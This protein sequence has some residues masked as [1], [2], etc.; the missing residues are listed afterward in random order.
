MGYSG[1]TK[2]HLLVLVVQRHLD[3][4]IY[5]GE[6]AKGRVGILVHGLPTG[7]VICAHKTIIGVVMHL[8][9]SKAKPS[10]IDHSNAGQLSQ[11]KPQPTESPQLSPRYLGK[12]T[13]FAI[14]LSCS[15]TKYSYLR[16]HLL[17]VISRTTLPTAR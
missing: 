5:N 2:L 10:C 14:H 16:P 8:H 12:T 15:C 9:W 11:T 3:A 13:N 4:Y 7:T 6:I 1:S 17:R